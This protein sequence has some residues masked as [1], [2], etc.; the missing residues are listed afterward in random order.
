MTY[1][2]VMR[3]G[4]VVLLEQQPP[5]MDGTEVLIT[6]VAASPGSSAAIL[7]AMETVPRVPAEWVD[8]LEQLIAEGRRP[9]TDQVPFQEEPSSLENE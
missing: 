2:G 8:E 1:R 6:P 5:L 7:A 4:M 3:G 9:P